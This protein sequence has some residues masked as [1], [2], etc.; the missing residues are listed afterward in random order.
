MKRL[1]TIALIGLGIPVVAE[2]IQEIYDLAQE[3][4][5]TFAIS[6][7]SHRISG[8]STATTATQLLPRISIGIPRGRSASRSS[9]EYPSAMLA[10]PAFD[11]LGID[12]AT[13][14]KWTAIRETRSDGWNAGL[15]Q[16]VFSLP[17]IINVIN[18]RRSKVAADYN[19]VSAE[20]DLII[21]VVSAY[22]AVL[23]A[24]DSVDNSL[25]SQ[26][27]IQRQLEQAQ[28]RFQVGLTASTDVL[29]AQASYD[30]SVVGQ[31]QTLNNLEIVF[32]RLQLFTGGQLVSELARLSKDFPIANPEP[33]DQEFW[34]EQA[35]L[36]NPQ[37]LAAQQNY[38]NTK[39]RHFGQRFR[40]LPVITL[41]A[42]YS[43]SE[44]PFNI[45]GTNTPYDL[46][47][48]SLGYSLGLSFNFSIN[49][50]SGI[51]ALRSSAL[52]KE[53]SRL[54][55]RRQRAVM[56]NEVR[57]QYRTVTTD[58]LRVDAR[59]RAIE[60]SQASL[61]ATE[62]GYEVGTRNIIEVL[63]AQ[64]RLFATELQYES[65]KYDYIANM[66][67][68]KQM[69]G[70]LSGKDIAEINRFMDY[71]NMAQRRMSLTGK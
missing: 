63:N 54:Q 23:R 31:I 20:H 59:R 44:S 10:D 42:N 34:V 37:Y 25:R 1:L 18:A 57:Q 4:D 28:Q 15:S 56:I 38:E 41:G 46:V 12:P 17:T 14:G 40:D 61:E 32:E 53:Q 8:I 49:S 39:L 6:K 69:A 3:F 60:S 16:T 62:T 50:G 58:V 52:S 35:L 24:R 22:F 7:V 68:L 5:S 70:V 11:F 71:D 29:N 43:F 2:D 45:G 19:F 51:M 36:N 33:N 67:R 27:A 9:T 48:E 65:A 55:L 64:Q 26:D 30:D 21:R 13:N 66:L 47:R